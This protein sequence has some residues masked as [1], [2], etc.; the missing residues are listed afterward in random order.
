MIHRSLL[1]AT[2]AAPALYAQDGGQLYTTYCAAC[3]GTN[4][5]GALNG[6]FP[7]LAGS[8]WPTGN[9]PDRAIK[10]VLHGLHGEVE[11]NGRSWNLEMPPQG[12]ALPDDQ[13]AAILTYVRKSW[14]NDAPAVSE[15][16]V[17]AIRSATASRSEQWT[18]EELLKAHPLDQ[19]AP[20]KDLISYLY[21]GEWKSIPDF[22]SMKA[23][24]VEEEH[25]GFISLSKIREK[26]N[27]GVVWLGTFEVPADAE[28]EFLLDAD[29]GGRLSVEGQM[30]A[31]IT[32]IGP[33]G[34][35][36][37]IVPLKLTKG[38]HKIRIEYHQ[39]TGNQEIQAAWRKKGS[40]Q[41]IWF[42]DQKVA[43]KKW[44]DIPII[45]DAKLPTIYRNFIEGSTPRAIGV[46]FNGGV[47]LA[48]SADHLG[49]DL[50]WTGK[51]MDGGHHWT[52][53][54]QGFEPPA[55]EN[56]AKLIKS[57]ALP[58][59]SKFLGYKFDQKGGVTF[60][61]QAGKLR[62]L[63]SYAAAPQGQGIVR[64]VSVSGEGSPINLL[65]ADPALNSTEPNKYPV[66]KVLTLS[67][68]KGT[69]ESKDGKSILKL[70]PGE[71]TTFN[72]RWK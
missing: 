3:H 18:P 20:L 7:P 41:W 1:L 36:Q 53:R 15:A 34:G 14:G 32:G 5:E 65:I 13:I 23:V 57:N 62:V 52:D 70:T 22:T 60:A 21:K 29:D 4:G 69:L 56:V 16:S 8:P 54:G 67:L 63:D 51:F 46:G 43:A 35:R 28:Y 38:D 12:A 27:Y 59:G 50:V 2:L 26:N 37:K 47:N 17:K 64:T 49:L 10:I 30:L 24:A 58:E 42:T 19:K 71:T 6:Q 31:E 72:Y 9:S 33:V 61:M 68:D 39:A 45:P 66:D 44:A 55:G 11:V 40:D 25:K 48:W